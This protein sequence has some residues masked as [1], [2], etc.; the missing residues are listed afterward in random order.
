[1]AISFVGS[2]NNSAAN[3]GNVTLTVPGGVVQNDIIIVAYTIGALIN[4]AMSVS[5]AGYTEISELYAN[6]STNDTNLAVYYKVQGATPDTTVTCVG[7]G[8]ASEAVTA[9]LMVFRGVDT[10]TPL[11]VTTTTATGTGTGRPTPPAITP[12]TAGSWIVCAG[13]GASD[14]QS[15]FT[16][17]G[18]L[19][20]TAGHFVSVAQADTVD[21]ATGMG[22]KTDWTSGAFTPAQWTGGSTA[23]ADSWAA[24]TLALRPGTTDQTL[25]PSLVTNSQT[26]HAPT[27]AAVTPLTPSL[28]TNTSSFF[29]PTVTSDYTLTPDLYTR[30]T[31]FSAPTVLGGDFQ[32]RFVGSLANDDSGG[33]GTSTVSFSGAFGLRDELNS[34][35]A[36]R[37]NDVV[38]V[39]FTSTYT[40]TYTVPTGWTELAT[41]SVTDGKTSKLHVWAKRMGATPDTQVILPQSGSVTHATAWTVHA[42]RDV[43]PDFLDVTAVTA[44]DPNSGQPNPPSVTPVTSGSIVLAVG[45]NSYFS[46]ANFA[47]SDLS[48]GTNHFRQATGTDSNPC[49][50]GAGFQTWTAGAFDPAAWTGGTTD[51]GSVWTAATLALRVTGQA[52]TLT[53]GLTT[54]TNTF[55]APIVSEIQPLLPGLVSNTSTFYAPILFQ[56]QFL[57]PSLFDISSGTELVTNGTFTSNTT[58]WT[59]LSDTIFDSSGGQGRLIRQVVDGTV[60]Q[61]ITTVVGKIYRVTG[62]LYAGTAPAYTIGV[63]TSSNSTLHGSATSV[64]TI[65]LTFTATTTSTRITLSC[66]GVSNDTAFFDN[67]SAKETTFKAATALNVNYILPSLVSNTN[68]FYDP[69]A[70]ATNPLAPSLV[71]NTS[72]FYS[73]TVLATYSLSASL[74]TNT[75]TIYAPTVSDIYGL[76]A[77]LVTNTQTFYSSS[78]LGEQSLQPILV[79]NSSSFYSATVLPGVVNLTPSLVT[80]ASS[81]FSISLTTYISLVPELAANDNYFYGSTVGILP[82]TSR[83]FSRGKAYS[84]EPLFPTPDEISLSYNREKDVLAK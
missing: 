26:F 25:T 48:T 56:D 16:N 20:T 84:S 65:D 82:K 31:T 45:A 12:V 9:V 52:R 73:P 35:P 60:Y 40:D 7:A 76:T 21:S 32:V 3:G 77:P 37:E 34:E 18:D 58:G 49:K 55:Y 1:M 62:N 14:I 44:S 57:T 72:V 17:P 13:G 67:I 66:T 50:I 46:S 78:I 42:F 28:V 33:T 81:F 8:G 5:T 36:L 19:S 22:F 2:A 70:L 75:S 63:G 10:T 24:F 11:D 27:V 54:N 61:D 39:S 23:A 30:T 79:T 38:I 64:P 71:T 47:N 68:T 43:D 69:T 74:L 59:A 83:A 29:A 6:G 51:T 4:A 80:N 41:V 15:A 53:P